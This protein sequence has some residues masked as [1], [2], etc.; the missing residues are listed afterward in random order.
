MTAFPKT[1]VGPYSFAPRPTDRLR[2]FSSPGLLP[3][4]TLSTTCRQN[5]SHSIESVYQ[6]ANVLQRLK[7]I[8]PT[9]HQGR[10][11]GKRR[12]T[13]LSKRR[14]ACVGSTATAPQPT[15]ASDFRLVRIRGRDSISHPGVSAPQPFQTLYDPHATWLRH[16]FSALRPRRGCG[17]AFQRK[18]HPDRAAPPR[19]KLRGGPVVF[20]G[21]GVS[22]DGWFLPMP[23]GPRFPVE[24]EPRPTPTRIVPSTKWSNT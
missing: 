2:L 20:L 3:N 11:V 16:V 4:Q 21:N 5:Y 23:V 1:L 12:A 14:P 22:G 15:V 17:V 9:P 8:R 24:I 6:L 7:P 10:P 19:G 18:M 13:A